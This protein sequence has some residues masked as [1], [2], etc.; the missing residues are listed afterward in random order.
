MKKKKYP[1]LEDY[2]LSDY[3]ELTG[4]ILYKIN[5]GAQIE[6]SNEAVANAQ[7]GD[8]LTRKNGTVVEITQGDIDWAREQVGASSGDG[9]SSSSSVIISVSSGSSSTQQNPTVNGKTS[10]DTSSVLSNSSGGNSSYGSNQNVGSSSSM[11]SNSTS[12]SSS[13]GTSNWQSYTPALTH[14]EQYEMAKADTERKNS[15]CKS[16]EEYANNT[17]SDSFITSF[18]KLKLFYAVSEGVGVNSASRI[19][20]VTQKTKSG[21]IE[22]SST[23]YFTGKNLVNSYLYGGTASLYVDNKLVETQNYSREEPVFYDGT[24]SYIGTASFKTKLDAFQSA[25]IISDIDLIYRQPE[26]NYFIN[27]TPTKIEIK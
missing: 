17:T 27:Y 18:S 10:S 4:D 3:I 2:D 7:V 24:K 25:Y 13:S 12:N 23:A 22:T 20:Y 26:G 8:S 6:N 14:Q 21:T 9:G 1:K 19:D 5:G 16:I 11:G 15:D